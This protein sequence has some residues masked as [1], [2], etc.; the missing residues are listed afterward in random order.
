LRQLFF[1]FLHFIGKKR[2]QRAF[3]YRRFS[4]TFATVNPKIDMKHIYYQILF[5]AWAKM[6]AA[7][8]GD[9]PFEKMKER[10]Y[11]EN[12]PELATL[13]NRVTVGDSTEG[14]RLTEQIREVAR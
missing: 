6:A 4:V 7:M 11:A 2:A 13:L 3:F 10:T 12:W 9:N 1:T 14:R 5:L 8:P